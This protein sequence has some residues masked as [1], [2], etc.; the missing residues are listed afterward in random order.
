MFAGAWVMI[1]HLIAYVMDVYRGEAAMTSP[2]ASAL[3][4]V[5]FPPLPAGPLWIAAACYV[6]FPVVF[7][8]SVMLDQV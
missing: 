7:A 5:Q 2:L 6:A 4:L 1:C 3:Y 8:I